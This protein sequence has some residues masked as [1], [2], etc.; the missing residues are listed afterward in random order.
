MG[1]IV[2]VDLDDPIDIDVCSDTSRLYIADMGR[3]YVLWRVNLRSGKQIEQFIQIRWRSWCQSV[4]FGR[5]LTTS[6]DGDKLYLYI[7][8]GELQ[9]YTEYPYYMLARHACR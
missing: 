6:C 9:R 8:N 2:A 5:L 3:S 1:D 7:D 4:N